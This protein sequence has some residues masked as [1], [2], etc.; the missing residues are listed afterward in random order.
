MAT[1]EQHSHHTP[2][3]AIGRHG[4]ALHQNNQGAFTKGHHIASEELGRK[5]THL[6]L[7][8]QGINS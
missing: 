8:L 4:R 7:C 5:I 1:N 6:P 2:A 3:P